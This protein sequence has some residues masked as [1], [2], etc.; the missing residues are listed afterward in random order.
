MV[1][2]SEKMSRSQRYRARLAYGLQ[3]LGSRGRTVPELPRAPIG[4]TD[5]AAGSAAAESQGWSTADNHAMAD[6]K[7][8]QRVPGLRHR[9]HHYW[10]GQA[11]VRLRTWD[12]TQC[13]FP[14]PGAVVAMGWV[15]G[16][17]LQEPGGPSRIPH[18]CSPS[19]R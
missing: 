15:F 6:S 12:A 14:A 1:P 16:R 4:F 10:T 7:V 5:L 11:V 18:S 19:L 13:T 3:G 8:R 17:A 9:W 2:G